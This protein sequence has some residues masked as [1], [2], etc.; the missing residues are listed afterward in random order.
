MSVPNDFMTELLY[1][2]R[3]QEFEAIAQWI[4]QNPAVQQIAKLYA[5]GTIATREEALF[6]MII[7]LCKDWGE[8]NRR[9]YELAMQFPEII[10]QSHDHH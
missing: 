7:H 4:D 8:Q 9:N 2:K 3:L 10:R 1:R 6:Q 5:N